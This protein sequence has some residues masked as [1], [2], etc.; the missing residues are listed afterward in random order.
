MYQNGTDLVLG[1]NC[2]DGPLRSR[3]YKIDYNGVVIGRD[4]SCGICF[5]ENAPGVSRQHCS[6][7]WVDG[8]L[9]LTDLN[10][11]YGTYMGDG[12]RL[13]PQY[14]VRLSAGSRFYVGDQRNLFQVIIMK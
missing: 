1:L 9:M 10:S 13:P 4:G 5:G 6:L 3:M 12:S 11:A 2:L 8:A 14:P 7:Y